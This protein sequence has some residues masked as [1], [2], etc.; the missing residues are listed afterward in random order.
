MHINFCQFL[1]KWSK[2]RFLRSFKI[3]S[4]ILE[5][6]I[7][8]LLLQTNLGQGKIGLLQCFELLWIHNKTRFSSAT[9]LLKEK[10]QIK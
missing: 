3:Y 10:N 4:R 6:M 8:K 9:L 2:N 7:I 5:G 1:S